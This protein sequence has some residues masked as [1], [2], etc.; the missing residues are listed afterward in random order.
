MPETA[1]DGTPLLE[2]EN[3]SLRAKGYRGYVGGNKGNWGPIG[4]LQFDYLKEHGLEPESVMLDVACGSLRAGR[5]FIPYLNPGNYLGIDIEGDLI[6][7]G[8]EFEVSADLAAEKQPEFVVS[9]D[10]DFGR[11]SKIP[12]M[13][14]ANSLFTHLVPS[15]IRRC[16]GQLAAHRHQGTV[17]YATF[18]A[19]DQP[20][21]NPETSDA[22]KGFFYTIDEM[23]SFAADAN[24]TAVYIGDWGHPRGQ[25]LM[26]FTTP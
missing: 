7:A 2:T 3:K 18:F 20:R 22:H 10:F 26:R 19:V 14:M 21:V 1:K 9:D 4:R 24:W 23:K 11:F 25:K 6:A 12:D 16:L 13:A 8:L 15:G 5:H 17:F